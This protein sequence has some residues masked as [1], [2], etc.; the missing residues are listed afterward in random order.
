MA[1]QKFVYRTEFLIE[2]SFKDEDRKHRRNRIGENQ[3]CSV[4]SS[5]AEFFPFQNDGKQH[6]DGKSQHDGDSRESDCPDENFEERP[7]NTGIGYDPDVVVEP[8]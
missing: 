2:E 7:L 1:S 4:S 6:S 3:E 5:E 8:G